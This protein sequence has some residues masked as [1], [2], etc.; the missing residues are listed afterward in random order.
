MQSDAM[1][2][3]RLS[4]QQEELWLSQREDPTHRA[5]VAVRLTG[6]LHPDALESALVEV[7]RRHEILRTT[8]RRRTG[9]KLPFQVVGDAPA[10]EMTEVDLR[11]ADGADRVLALLVAEGARAVDLERG[12]LLHA[13]LAALGEDE[14]AL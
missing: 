9:M 2:G 1:S 4:P 6:A 7:A 11:G 3:F 13:T 10:L 5:V 14:H 8:F 12:P